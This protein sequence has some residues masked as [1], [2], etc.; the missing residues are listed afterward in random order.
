MA[1]CGMLGIKLASRFSTAGTGSKQDSFC[2]PEFAAMASIW[3]HITSAASAL[4]D[5]RM[6]T[7][8][9]ENMLQEQVLQL[10]ATVEEMQNL[11]NHAHMVS[12][13]LRAQ[14]KEE[15]RRAH[16]SSPEQ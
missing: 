7:A 4:C 1:P 14:L 16:L 10:Q 11:L 8:R 15:R 9:T 3:K 2:F 5:N 13:E 12:Q 6:Y